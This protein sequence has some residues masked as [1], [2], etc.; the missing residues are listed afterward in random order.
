MEIQLSDLTGFFTDRQVV[1][2][3]TGSLA[4]V[5]QLLGPLERSLI[6]IADS[7]G[8]VLAAN[9]LGSGVEPAVAG[10]IALRLAEC[11]S[12]RDTCRL[13]GLAVLEGRVLFG[14][15]LH[16]R[17]GG[18][19]LGVAAPPSA[20]A[21]VPDEELRDRLV[22]AGSLAWDVLR[23]REDEA[24]LHTQLRHL[25]AEQ[26]TR[27]ASYSRVLVNAIEEREERV[28]VQQKYTAQIA[29]VMKTTPDGII[30]IDE[31]DRI[32]SFNDAA[33]RTFGYA[34][35]EVMGRNVHESL[36]AP[37]YRERYR[38]ILRKLQQRGEGAVLGGFLELVGIRKSGEEFPAELS[39]SSPWSATSPSENAARRNWR[40][41]ARGCRNWSRS[42]RRNSPRPTGGSARKSPSGPGRSN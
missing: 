39:L 13:S 34:S 20:L 10:P 33:T 15:R 32:V 27:K 29:A 23:M 37:Q 7:Q 9:A 41:T 28:Q 25:Q 17:T 35:D 2:D 42:A 3:R 1:E 24:R 21:Q 6:L 16:Q 31:E 5:A 8:S 36:A 11:L 19:I 26:D 38:T 18:A 30:L 4:S 22:A 14:V 12:G 40:S